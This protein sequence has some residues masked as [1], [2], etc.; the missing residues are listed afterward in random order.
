MS[1]NFANTAAVTGVAAD[2]P[3]TPPKLPS[4]TMQYKF[5]FPPNAAMSGKPRPVEFQALAGGQFGQF[6]WYAATTSA[7][8]AGIPNVLEKPP[9]LPDHAV[10]SPMTLLVAKFVPPTAV[11][12]GD[13]AGKPG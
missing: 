2:V 9:P 5:T 8:Y 4:S 6:C 1:F 12:N 11:T 13:A 10:S 7:W 3:S